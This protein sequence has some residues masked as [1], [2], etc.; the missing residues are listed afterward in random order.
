M[1]NSNRLEVHAYKKG[2]RVT[3]EGDFIGL[4][5]AKNSLGL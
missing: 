5:G 3:K 2:F 4:R 1:N